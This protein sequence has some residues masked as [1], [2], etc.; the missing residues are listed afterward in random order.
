M[1][2]QF[3]QKNVLLTIANKTFCLSLHYNG[4]FSYLFVNSKE[5]IKFKAKNQ[6]NV[7]QE[8]YH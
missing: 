3:M 2:Q 6:K 5:V 1:I 7:Y 4:D 8:N